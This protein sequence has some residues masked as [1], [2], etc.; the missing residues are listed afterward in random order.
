VRKLLAA[1]LLGL[2]LAGL[3][4]VSATAAP[5]PALSVSPPANLVDGQFVRLK[6]TG[7]PPFSGV[8][9]AQC[10]AAPLSFGA[11]CT[12][13][14]TV[15]SGITGPGGGG[16]TYSQVFAGSDPLLASS[17]RSHSITCD[18]THACT[19]AAFTAADDPETC[20]CNGLP[21]ATFAPLTFARSPDACPTPGPTSVLGSGASSAYRAMFGWESSVCTSPSNLSVG[22]AVHNS[23]NGVADFENGL[24]DFGVVG[25]LKTA[26][27]PTSLT[28]RYAPIT[29]SALVLAY[30][31]YDRRGPQITHLVLS[32]HI[33]A[34]MFTGQI[35]NWNADPDIQALNPGVQFP[36]REVTFARAEH[37]SESFVFTSWLAATAPDV[38]ATCST[39]AGCVPLGPQEIFPPPASGVTEVTGSEL[40]GLGVAGISPPFDQQHQGNIGFMD[41]STAAFYGLPTVIIEQNDLSRV[42]ANTTT[43]SNAVADSTVAADGT[44]ALN[45]DV[46]PRPGVYPMP[47]PTY[48]LAPTNTIS[49]CKGATLAAFLKYAVQSGQQAANLPSGSEFEYAPLPSNLVQESLHVAAQIPASTQCGST[50]ATIQTTPSSSLAL[51]PASLAPLPAATP[52]A[53][54]RSTPVAARAATTA[55]APAAFLTDQS[56]AFVLPLILALGLAALGGGVATQVMA[57]RESASAT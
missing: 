39:A 24:T 48:V 29:M 9:F 4:G 42:E 5:S 31:I 3:A 14:S 2:P 51:T 16:F 56:P 27:P 49:P 6:F 34:Q 30:R 37:S 45:D 17:D 41:S 35:P 40:M 11:D 28:Y 46:P 43:V 53:A 52:A 26:P 12:A 55:A 33:I 13:V 15:N 23:V 36:T 32:P 10:T 7:F 1:L 22:F 54:P 38:W 8:V 44:L 20:G 18:A 21:S 47:M 57:R 50:P 19:L 25:P